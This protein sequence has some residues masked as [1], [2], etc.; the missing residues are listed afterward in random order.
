MAEVVLSQSIR[1]T[2]LLA[3]NDAWKGKRARKHHKCRKSSQYE[4]IL[5]FARVKVS[6]AI[7]CSAASRTACVNFHDKVLVPGDAI[8][9]LSRDLE[10]IGSLNKYYHPDTRQH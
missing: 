2:A 10:A 7:T 9:L 4:A 3:K 8:L 6:E 1:D 5:K